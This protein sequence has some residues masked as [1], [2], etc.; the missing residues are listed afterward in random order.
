MEKLKRKMFFINCDSCDFTVKFEHPNETFFFC[1]EHRFGVNVP[2]E[3][4]N[5]RHICKRCNKQMERY[6][7]YEEDNVC[8]LCNGM[9]DMCYQ[10]IKLPT[11]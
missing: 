3:D 2:D 1:K 8:P 5:L 9:F 4:I 10:F 6:D 11:P 7:L